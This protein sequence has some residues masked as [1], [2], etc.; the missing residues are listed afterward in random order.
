MSRYG[1]TNEPGDHYDPLPF[2]E[3]LRDQAK[4][5]FE[6]NKNGQIKE[7][8]T[9]T[10][11]LNKFAYLDLRDLYLDIKSLLQPHIQRISI[12]QNC[13]MFLQG[14]ILQR[15]YSDNQIVIDLLQ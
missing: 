6:I 4:A 8:Q 11:I 15:D 3:M 7:E 14:V 1:A 12:P 9:F 2:F 5:K 10:Y 13:L